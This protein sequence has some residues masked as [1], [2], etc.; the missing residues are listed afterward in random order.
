MRQ[1]LLLR[2]YSRHLAMLSRLFTGSKWKRIGSP[3]T[4]R[5]SCSCHLHLLWRALVAKVIKEVGSSLAHHTGE[6]ETT[7]IKLLFQQLQL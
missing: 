2:L 1:P 7:T 6:E 5:E 3:A 4:I